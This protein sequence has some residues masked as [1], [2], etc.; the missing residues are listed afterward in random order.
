MP[1]AIGKDTFD[2]V[3]IA[4]L[5]AMPH[6]LVAGST[7]AGKSVFINTL[8]VSL[9]VKKSPQEMKL[10]LI[11]PKQLELILYSDLPHLAL[12]VITDPQIASISLAWACQEMDRRYSIL[13]E[14]GVR[15]IDS[16]NKKLGSASKEQLERIKKYYASE[17]SE[18]YK[19]PYIVVIIDEFADLI[20][21]KWGKDIEVSVCRL[22]AKAR[23]AGVHL[24]VA[25]QR[26]SVDVI[27]G[28][29][30]SNFP[31]RISFRVTSSI[32]SRTILNSL[33]AEKLLGHGDMLYRSGIKMKRLHSAYVGEREIEGLMNELGESDVK[34]TSS[35]M[36]KIENERIEIGD[37][38]FS[39]DQ[40]SNKLGRDQKDTLYV[41]A[42]KIAK[43]QR[44]V[45]ASML[46]RRL[47]IGYNRAAN[48]VEYMESDGIVGPV[49]GSKPREI[50]I[51]IEETDFI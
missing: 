8:L 9:L 35:A 41:D 6:M 34:Y 46:Q 4:D 43:E 45:S 22:A 11:D 14:L 16:F 3:F 49:H 42:I 33:G 15:N 17:K 5:A 26:P 28:L 13:K 30:K 10:L 27:T 39:V 21:S 2:E 37:K 38:S 20:L 23:A 44:C 7:G 1:I 24:V 32:D 50:L 51:D 40:V 29:I 25:T 48:M 19:L 18:S 47:R 12:P 31:T 36:E